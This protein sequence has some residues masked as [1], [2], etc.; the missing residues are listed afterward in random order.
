[1]CL[2]CIRSIDKAMADEVQKVSDG[3]G[4]P[5]EKCY[6]VLRVMLVAVRMRLSTMV[7]NTDCALE[8]DATRQ[9]NMDEYSAFLFFLL[10]QLSV[11]VTMLVQQRIFVTSKT[12]VLRDENP[13]ES[14]QVLSAALNNMDTQMRAAMS[15]PHSTAK[16]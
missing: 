12:S 15:R 4:T 6:K 11:T 7:D 9:E 8:N 1:M 2:D 16:N 3:E 14:A 5:D 13:F 10:Q